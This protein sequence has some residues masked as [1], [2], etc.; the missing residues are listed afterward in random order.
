MWDAVGE[1]GLDMRVS[2][3]RPCVAGEF[4]CG[5]GE[6]REVQEAELGRAW[7]GREQGTDG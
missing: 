1:S 4:A 2:G 7:W 5:T 6:V 3:L